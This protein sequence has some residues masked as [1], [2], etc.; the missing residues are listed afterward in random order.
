MWKLSPELEEGKR[1][2]EGQ[3]TVF[4]LCLRWCVCTFG[5]CVCVFTV[6][7]QVK[8]VCFSLVSCGISSRLKDLKEG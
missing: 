3:E 6:E 1:A 8:D 5:V 4:E 2:S 7:G